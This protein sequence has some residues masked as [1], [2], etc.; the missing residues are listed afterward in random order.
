MAM[1]GIYDSTGGC[2]IIT[3]PSQGVV[4]TLHDR[5]PVVLA[6]DSF[7]A[8]LDSSVKDARPILAGATADGLTCYPVSFAVNSVRN[9]E[10]KLIERVSDPAAEL[11]KGKTLALF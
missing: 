5:M 4:A 9:D 10:P 2:A 11:P 6:P 1:A 7:A 8:W 3:A